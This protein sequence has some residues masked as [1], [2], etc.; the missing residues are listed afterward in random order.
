MP[1]GVFPNKAPTGSIVFVQFRGTVDAV[2]MDT[3]PMQAV[4]L[5]IFEQGNPLIN[6]HTFLRSILE[7]R[8][9]TN[10]V[11]LNETNLLLTK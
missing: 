4:Q 10:P 3:A 1:Q 8:P 11:L 6:V 9:A 7:Y 5:S 2:L